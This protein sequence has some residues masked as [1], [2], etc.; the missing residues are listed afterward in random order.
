[1]SLIEAVNARRS[2]RKYINRPIEPAVMEQLQACAKEVSQSAGARIE[3]IFDNGEAFRG[4]RRNYGL[5]AGVRHY[6]GLIADPG[7]KTAVERLGYYG[8]LFMLRAVALGL[9]TCWVGGSYDR[10][11]C[12]FALSGKEEVVCAIT[13]G[14]TPEQDN[15]R[16]KL[17]QSL[18]HRKTKS[19][20]DMM[21][22]ESPVPEWFLAGMA[23]VQKAPSANNRQ[24]VMF[25]YRN[26]AVTAESAS[27]IDLGIAKLHFEL[28]TGGGQSARFGERWEFGN[29]GTFTKG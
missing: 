25:T 22:A 4:L 2:R 26:G 8:E 24:P 15:A 5:L 17:I 6:A 11:L 23:A 10:A 28:G 16:E 1:M 21:S 14:D 13:F 27:A 18:T 9:G 20:E 19:I 3:L 12:P 29:N 7:D